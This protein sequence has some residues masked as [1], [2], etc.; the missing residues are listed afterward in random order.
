MALPGRPDPAVTGGLAGSYRWAIAALSLAQ[1]M[2]FLDTTIINVALPAI[3]QAMRLSGPE[4][5]WMVT[6]YAVPFGGLLLLGGRIGDIYGRR[7]VLLA[8]LFLFTA[9][10]LLGGLAQAPWWL[11]SCRA[12][13]GI[14]AAAA[15]PATLALITATFPEDPQRQRAIGTLNVIGGSGP[16]S[17]CWLAA[18]SPP[19]CHGAG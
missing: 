15:F 10:S 6:A 18:S 3:Q 14:G 12:I 4:L 1:L 2:V 19:T 16:L 7:R 8:G 5:E 11:L 9:A 17:G 13:Q